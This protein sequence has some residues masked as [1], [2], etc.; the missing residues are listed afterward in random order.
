[1]KE[2]TRNLVTIII[3]SIGLV[4]TV[5]GII[6]AYFRFRRENPLYP[7]IE[8]N[9]DCKFF[10]PQHNSCLTAITISANNKGNIEHKF[11]EIRIRIRGIKNNEPL[12]EFKEYPPMVEFPVEVMKGVNIVPAK[13]EMVQ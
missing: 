10:T 8:F 12:K 9:L 6:W 11:S 2:E 13:Y 5:I 3:N 7:R 4:I 1:M